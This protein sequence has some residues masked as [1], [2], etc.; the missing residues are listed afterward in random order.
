MKKLKL[1]LL[2][3]FFIST[4]AIC[5][6]QQIKIVSFTVKNSL[7]SKVDEWGTIPAAIILTAQKAPTIQLKEPKLVIQIRSG[8]SI[9][10]GNNQST[11]QPMNAFDVK[12]FTANE[13]I[14]MLSNC[15]ELKEGS[16]QLCAQ[17]FNLDRIAISNEVCKE[18]KVESPKLQEYAPP[19]LI[20][21]EDGKNFTEAELS[22]PLSFR[23][24]PLVPKPQQPVTYRL[25]VWQL[26]QGQNGAAAMRSNPPIVTKDVDNITQAVVT[27]I[28]TGP[29]RPPYLCDFVWQVQALN[30]EGKPIGN[31]EGKS[32]V[33]KFG[34]QEGSKTKPPTLIAPADNSSQTKDEAG[35]G[36]KFRWTPIVPKP[37]EPVTYRLKV[38]QLM[39][40]QTGSQAM[41][42]N[43]PIV[44]KDVA[45]I[46]EAIVSGIYTGPC[47]PPYLCDYVWEV[48]ALN[49]EGKPLG[50]NEGKSEVFKFGIQEAGATKPP[51]LVFPE[52]NKGFSPNDAL[53]PITFRWTPLVPK[54]KDQ[55][56]YRLKVWQLMQG[57]TSS[58]A[59]RTNK[60]I[61]TKDVADITEATVSGIY[62]G[63]CR[64]P[65][66]CDYV[67][68]VQAIDR[69]GNPIGENE[70][71]S[72]A[73]NFKIQ[74]NI[75]IQID[76]VKVGCCKDGKQSISIKIKNNLAT[77]VNIVVIKY[78]IN[79]AGAAITLT[80]TV[81]PLPPLQ[82]VA[83]NGTITFTANVNCIDNLNFLKFLV[84][85]EDVAD[86]DNKETEV[87]SD[88]L[89]CACDACDEKHFT[90]NAPKPDITIQ[91]NTISFNQPL[92]ITTSP[93]KPIKSIKADL[94]YFEMTP[95]NDMC[96]P[97]NKDAATYGHFTNGTNSLQW[98][99][100]TPQSPL[101]INITMPQLTPCCSAKFKWCIRY[102]IEFTDCTTCNKLVC[103]EKE[104]QGCEKGGGD[105]HQNNNP[106][107]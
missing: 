33:Y 100:T 20:T 70:G 24:T 45:D 9:I 78:K 71:K 15:K 69:Q 18:F 106:K 25:K 102:K 91:N 10:C 29:C 99:A 59:M 50:E 101:A 53:K 74:N 49:R 93:S 22:R 96:I 2:S 88:T 92:T 103:Y 104:K 85:A 89:H 90:L 5:Q 58:Q 14:G 47:R 67:W 41:R 107:K 43:K 37:Q 54:P 39:Q 3:L 64:P 12:T 52:N 23:W 40:G 31:N 65:Y 1:L 27:G 105:D 63:P 79:G 48:Q 56:T 60:P 83:G 94:V 57:Q 32:E 4:A 16:Y 72:E 73:W 77:P 34:V 44:T 6:L 28:Y 87:K 8:G 81:P 95:E 62:T 21:P 97:C 17:F 7:P 61:V 98:A 11:A 30:R 42:T 19:T 35:L 84:D 13:I 80:P 76:S 75:D 51:T 86:P 36:L 68:Q 38:W 26:M 82:T 55:V 66:L 46:T